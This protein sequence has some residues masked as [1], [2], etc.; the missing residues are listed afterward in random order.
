MRLDWC[1]FGLVINMKKSDPIGVFDSGL[2]GLSV[3]HTLQKLLPNENIIYFGDSARN[4]YGTRSK[5]EVRKFSFEIVEQMKKQNV[6]AIVIACNTA[7]S[8][9]A[10]ELR[11]AYD[12]DIV[13]MEPA[14]KPAALMKTPSNIAVWA[15]NLTLH[16]EK[17]ARLARRFA[18]DHKII[19]VAC[20]KLVELVEADQLDQGDKVD[21]ALHDYLEQSK[22]AEFIVL[23]CTHFL[24]YKNRLQKLVEPGLQIVDG[25]EGTV[26]HLA[27]LL[28]AKGLLNTEPGGT[29]TIQ[30]S[31]PSKIALS[32]KLLETLEGM[33][34]N[35]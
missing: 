12:F 4:P 31:D 21:A 15:T 30:N 17:F 14:L 22:D 5:E 3:V 32:W 13:G 20:S 33:E 27:A 25:N 16:Q 29:L 11:S 28:D 26:R 9:A 2:G 8:A 34:S 24:F 7:T 18:S 35:E 6:K 10:N 1:I 23:G 19:D